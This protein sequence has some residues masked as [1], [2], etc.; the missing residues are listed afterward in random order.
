M[1]TVNPEYTE[2]NN[3][4]LSSVGVAVV[5][6]AIHARLKN[7]VRPPSWLLDALQ[8]IEVRSELLSKK[9]AHHR[10]KVSQII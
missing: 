10:D 5:A 4:H 8:D 7:Q 1:S 2:R 3:L 9:L 6:K